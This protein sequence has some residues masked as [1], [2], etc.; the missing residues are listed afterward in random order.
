MS[1]IAS[2][3]AVGFVDTTESPPRVTSVR[4]YSAKAGDI[5]TDQDRA[6]PFDIYE[7]FGRNYEEACQ[8]VKSMLEQPYPWAF[9][10]LETGSGAI[11]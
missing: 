5:A 4:I 7:S 8:R 9:K 2:A 11:Q 10:L 3:C 1:K 6:F